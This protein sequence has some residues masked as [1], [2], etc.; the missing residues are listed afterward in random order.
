[1]KKI[2]DGPVTELT[3]SDFYNKVVATVGGKIF[4]L[5]RD[6]Y[7][8]PLFWNRS[9]LRY[10]RVKRA[11]RGVAPS[12]RNEQERA[13][14][15]NDSRRERERNKKRAGLP[16]SL[17]LSLAVSEITRKEKSRELRARRNYSFRKN[18]NTA[19]GL[20]RN[21]AMNIHV[22]R[23]GARVSFT[24]K[25]TRE[26]PLPAAINCRGARRVIATMTFHIA[27]ARAPA[28]ARSLAL[29]RSAHSSGESRTFG[30]I[31]MTIRS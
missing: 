24:I 14:T 26:G 23:S 1:M 8:E 29:T 21:T 27:P 28:R 25:I 3:R 31:C 16:L 10:G 9:T 2:H 5:W 4:A 6:D 15:P 12:S 17:S 19:R 22:T 20:A 13:G 30:T 11:L 7:G 18:V